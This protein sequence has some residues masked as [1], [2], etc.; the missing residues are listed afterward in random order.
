LRLAAW[1]SG[2]ECS[3]Q[4]NRLRAEK[5]E[6]PKVIDLKPEKHEGRATEEKK[7]SFALENLSAITNFG[8]WY[9]RLGRCR[10]PLLTSRSLWSASV[11]D[12]AFATRLGASELRAVVKVGDRFT[13]LPSASVL[14][15]RV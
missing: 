7:C 11:G 9:R 15:L 4:I 8:C 12:T 2:P 3:E 1:K 14:A 5:G 10:K 13:R 6:S